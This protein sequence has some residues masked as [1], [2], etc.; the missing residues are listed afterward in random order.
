MSGVLDHVR[1]QYDPTI[2]PASTQPTEIERAQTI[3]YMPVALETGVVLLAACIAAL[4]L[5]L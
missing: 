2:N 3:V 4:L 1:T 5:L